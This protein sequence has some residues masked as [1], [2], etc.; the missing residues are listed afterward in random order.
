M[1][2]N[3][4]IKEPHLIMEEESE[5]S[6]EQ[7]QLVRNNNLDTFKGIIEDNMKRLIEKQVATSKGKKA[8]V[9]KMANI[10]DSTCKK[11]DMQLIEQKVERA[12][13]RNWFVEFRSKLQPDL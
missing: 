12:I 6:G 2:K 10:P 8:Q 7:T 13:V 5:L 3:I 4:Y 9:E 1:K 11:E